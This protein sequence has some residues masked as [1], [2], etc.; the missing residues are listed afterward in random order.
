MHVI[1]QYRRADA[2]QDA[3]AEVL[4]S[5]WAGVPPDKVLATQ[6]FFVD[7]MRHA[8][9][10]ELTVRI[11]PPCDCGQRPSDFLRLQSLRLTCG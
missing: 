4:G 3:V 8:P 5:D 6:A 2:A 11:S 7:V 1:M 9:A 10:L